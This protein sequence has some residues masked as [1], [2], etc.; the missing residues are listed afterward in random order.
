MRA[1]IAAIKTFA[2]RIAAR[3]AGSLLVANTNEIAKIAQ[4]PHR[5]LRKRCENLP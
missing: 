4:M 5:M 2:Q 1:L 3:F